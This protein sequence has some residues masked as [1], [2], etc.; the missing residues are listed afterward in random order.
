LFMQHFIKLSATFQ[1]R[2]NEEIEKRKNLATM[3]KTILSS[4]LWTVMTHTT[5]NN[6]IQIK[7]K[8]SDKSHKIIQA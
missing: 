6:M 3:L 7:P 4:L 5:T 8:Y 2:D 1:Y